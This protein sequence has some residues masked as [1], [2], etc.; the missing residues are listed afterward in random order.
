MTD[1][2]VSSDE[3]GMI[4]DTLT[5]S[6]ARYKQNVVKIKKD[7]Y[8]RLEYGQFLNDNLI[9][10]SVY[11]VLEGT[12]TKVNQ[13]IHLFSTQFLPNLFLHQKALDPI[14]QE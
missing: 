13:K 9:E 5:I 10:F 12:S 7:D 8:S 2:S 6:K 3:Q 11:K 1:I 14:V 4:E